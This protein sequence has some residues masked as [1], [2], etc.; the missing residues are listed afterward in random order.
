MRLTFQF[1]SIAAFF[2]MDSYWPYVWSCYGMAVLV[3]IALVI[4]GHLRRRRFIR[5]QQGILRRSQPDTMISPD[6]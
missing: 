3:I 6:N 5:I 1:E 2:A 4:S